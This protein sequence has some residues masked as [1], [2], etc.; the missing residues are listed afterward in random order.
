MMINAT[1]KN[2][3]SVYL[4][5]MSACAPDS[6][7]ESR[8]LSETTSIE[9]EL[10]RLLDDAVAADP[11][12]RGALLGVEAP[13]RGLRWRGA[14]GFADPATGQVLDQRDPFR[15]CSVTKPL[16]AALVLALTE[17]PLTGKRALALSDLASL[18]LPPGTMRSLVVIDGVDYGVE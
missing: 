18:Y 11:S 17:T 10:Q 7:P 9:V 13:G 15:I 8:T 3:L 5:A 2:L 1:S 12:I 6:R 4:L 16:T 14:S